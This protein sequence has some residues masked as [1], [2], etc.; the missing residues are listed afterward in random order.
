MAQ[1][2]PAAAH[3][4]LRR[5]GPALRLTACTLGAASQSSRLATEPA[6]Q[7][8]RLVVAQR[9]SDCP[10]RTCVAARGGNPPA[11]LRQRQRVMMKSCDDDGII[12]ARSNRLDLR[13]TGDSPVT[14]CMPPE[15]R[16]CT[17][18]R[19]VAKQGG[20]QGGL[21]E[22]AAHHRAGES[23]R[24]CAHPVQLLKQ[25]PVQAHKRAQPRRGWRA[26]D[27]RAGGCAQNSG[28]VCS[29]VTRHRSRA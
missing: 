7:S 10:A 6:A 4:A 2:N 22:E 3:L 8:I 12:M 26:V 21:H 20:R 28:H 27:R 13:M 11:A 23:N 17:W 16:D 15:G 24:T 18:R 1:R 14:A 9:L 19:G 29:L 5:R 25:N